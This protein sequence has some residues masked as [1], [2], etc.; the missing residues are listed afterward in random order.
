MKH[1]RV[2]Q[3]NQKKAG[4]YNTLLMLYFIEEMSPAFHGEW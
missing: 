4:L 2:K 3:L 1:V